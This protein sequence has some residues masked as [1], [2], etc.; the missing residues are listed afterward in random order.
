[1]GPRARS[2]DGEHGARQGRQVELWNGNVSL[3]R[4]HSRPG[5]P[6]GPRPPIDDGTAVSAIESTSE[7]DPR[8]A[9]SRAR[10]LDATLAELGE[11]G[12]AGLSIEGIAAR[13][14][15][16][17]ATVYRHF[18]DRADLVAQAIETGPDPLPVPDS[19]DLRE[20]LLTILAELVER[21][22]GPAASLFPILI[23]AAERDAELGAHRHAFV[24]ARRRPLLQVLQAG[25]ARGDLP[26][27][28]DLDLLADLLAAPLFYRRFVSRAP[29]DA[30]FAAQVVDAVLAHPGG[31]CGAAGTGPGRP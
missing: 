2:N 25:I 17:K 11:H 15:V 12:Y 31:W 13:A 7:L 6:Y 10:I 26:P 20:D 5:P 22:H 18:P 28:V 3:W 19:G 30:T 1:M 21:G 27:T 8:V 9:R 16:G 24:R 14:G 4:G 23:D 29:V